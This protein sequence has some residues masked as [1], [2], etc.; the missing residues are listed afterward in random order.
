MLVTPSHP[1]LASHTCHTCPTCSR[2]SLERRKRRLAEEA[3]DE[4]DRQAEMREAEQR[5]LKRARGELP[6][7]PSPPPPQLTPSAGQQQWRGD[8]RAEVCA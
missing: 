5:A 4:A 1:H 8:S 7:S 2:R 3:D 6:L